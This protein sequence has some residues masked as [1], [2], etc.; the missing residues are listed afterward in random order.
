MRDLLLRA[1][2]D[3]HV[4]F[5]SGPGMG[6]YVRR[7]S[8]FFDRALPMPNTLPPLAD[9]ETL[10][11]YAEK[12][13]AAAPGLDLVL[14]IKLFPGMS[15]DTVRACAR[16]GARVGKYY[17]AGAT[18]HSRDGIPT[19]REI[20]DALEALEETGMVLSVHGEDPEAPVLERE[21][22]FLPV[23]RGLLADHPRLRVVLEHLSTREA[24]EFVLAGPDRL[25]A[26][27]T[28]HHL[29]FTT[30]DLA[31]GALRPHL[32][33]KPVLQDRTHRDALR[34]AVLSC[35]R[36]FFGSDSAPHPRGLK[37]SGEAPAGVYAAPVALPLL[38]AVFEEEEA[39]DRLEAFVSFRGARFYG[40]PPNRGRIRL[41]RE[42]W[43]VP[44]EMDGAVPAA[45]GSTLAWNVERV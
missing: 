19:P 27:V 29:S 11:A 3:F 42:P 1:P 45:A 23:L 44:E 26:T 25:G 41:T 15:A 5:R 31:G 8:A 38:A 39:L 40:L 24:A 34:K 12:V 4:H 16:A 18:T 13:R 9:P 7:T 6:E 30:D 17:P 10:A 14:S 22:A 21:R 33:C 20:R 2:D 35:D 32:F 36:V 43:T 28:A 37:E